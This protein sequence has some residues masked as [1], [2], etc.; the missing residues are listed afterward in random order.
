MRRGAAADLVADID[1]I[2]RD[3]AAFWDYPPDSPV[4]DIPGFVDAARDEGRHALADPA[5]A[6]AALSHEVALL[7]GADLPDLH[8]LAAPAFLYW[9]STD[10]LVPLEHVGV[11]QSRLGRGTTTR[12]YLRH[13]HDVQYLHWPEILRDIA[14]AAW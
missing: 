4:H 6:G 3:P 12:I 10:A 13:G 8:A 5:R 14:G 1:A 9:G 11:W 2:V 7:A